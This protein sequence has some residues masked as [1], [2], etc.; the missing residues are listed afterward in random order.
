MWTLFNKWL[1]CHFLLQQVVKEGMCS[2]ECSKAR[3]HVTWEVRWTATSCHALHISVC[4]RPSVRVWLSLRMCVCVRS[5]SMLVWVWQHF[6]TYI[7]LSTINCKEICVNQVPLWPACLLPLAGWLSRS[8][9]LIKTKETISSDFHFY[10]LHPAHPPQ[11]K[12]IP[13]L[14]IFDPEWCS[15]GST[16]RSRLIFLICFE[17][18]CNVKPTLSVYRPDTPLHGLQGS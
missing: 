10:E 15:E 14:T 4:V 8:A 9:D 5:L 16:A 7:L 2:Y 18:P 13:Q 1:F 11:K 3:W 17:S 6:L 12:S